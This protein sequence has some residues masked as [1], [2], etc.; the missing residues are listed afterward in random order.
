MRVQVRVPDPG[1]CAYIPACRHARACTNTGVCVTHIRE[2]I[3][4]RSKGFSPLG[5]CVGIVGGIGFFRWSLGVVSVPPLVGRGVVVLLWGCVWACIVRP[6]LCTGGGCGLCGAPM[7]ASGCYVCT[8]RR[9]GVR[10]CSRRYVRARA[11][12]R[13]PVHVF[14]CTHTPGFARMRSGARALAS[15]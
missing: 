6:L 8:H 11:Q 3:L 7:G 14:A 13:K 4:S 15:I 10:T 2:A 9:A 1:A 5:W 12:T